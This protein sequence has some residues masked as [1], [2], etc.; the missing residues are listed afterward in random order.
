MIKMIWCEDANHGIGINNKLPWS[1]KEEMDHF[2]TTTANSIVVMGRKT[3]D[4]IG[5]PLPNR[6]NVIITKNKFFLNNDVITYNSIE[7]F[8][9]DFKNKNVFVIGGKSI[10]EQFLPFANELIVSKL[11]KSYNCDTFICIDKKDFA[12]TNVINKKDFK[13]EYYVKRE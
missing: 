11:N 12:L 10:Y 7:D 2:K 3:F 8:V 9:K 1:I 13:I 6:K 5:R 4:S